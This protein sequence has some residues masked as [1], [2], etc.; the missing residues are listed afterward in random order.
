MIFMAKVC[1]KAINFATA[2]S[3]HQLLALRPHPKL[4]MI[5]IKKM[6]IIL[7]SLLFAAGFPGLFGRSM[8]LYADQVIV[9]II[10]FIIVVISIIVVII[11]VLISI[12]IVLIIIFLSFSRSLTRTMRRFIQ[13]L[14]PSPPS[15]RIPWL[16]RPGDHD[17]YDNALWRKPLRN[18]KLRILPK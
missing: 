8:L 15:W 18:L 11:I 5:I 17:D 10:V 6:I 4:I 13:S 9:L 1:P 12:I 16:R 7:I 3:I 14:V 2:E